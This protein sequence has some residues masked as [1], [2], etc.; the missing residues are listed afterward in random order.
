MS[1]RQR[2]E[3]G[4]TVPE[5]ADYVPVDDSGKRTAG[6]V[7]LEEGADFPPLNRAEEAWVRVEGPE[8]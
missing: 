3:P 7:P 1:D 5:S 8:G 6:P 4:T 2:H